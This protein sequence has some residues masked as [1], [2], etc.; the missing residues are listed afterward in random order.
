[1]KSQNIGYKGI[2]T[3]SQMLQT[4]PS[5]QISA[6][7]EQTHATYAVPFEH[8]KLYGETI[9]PSLA[10]DIYTPHLTTEISNIPYQDSISDPGMAA[11]G[12]MSDLD[13][14]DLPMDSTEVAGL[15]QDST[16]IRLVSLFEAKSILIAL[17]LEDLE[18][19]KAWKAFSAMD[20]DKK[21]YMPITKELTHA[22]TT[23]NRL[24]YRVSIAIHGH[25]TGHFSAFL[26]VPYDPIFAS[27]AA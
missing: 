8:K 2:D 24:I 23:F 15:L 16:F 18:G 19:S 1:M 22:N 5:S 27:K 14:E 4:P 20:G 11:D 21:W 6:I 13:T 3:E 25:A 17:Q 26:I 12:I 9:Q 7:A 10:S